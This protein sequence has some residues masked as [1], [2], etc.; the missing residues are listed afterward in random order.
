MQRDRHYA[1]NLFS[2]SLVGWQSRGMRRSR[3][4]APWKNSLEKPAI[5][6]CISRVVDRR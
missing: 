6:H 4:L 1:D 5:Y 3:W 2:L